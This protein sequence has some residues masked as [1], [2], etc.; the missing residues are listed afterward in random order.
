[1]NLLDVELS[2]GGGTFDG[3]TIEAQTAA[4]N[5]VITGP[6]A[7]TTGSYGIAAAQ[8]AT[9]Q[10]GEFNSDGDYTVGTTTTLSDTITS[11]ALVTGAKY[12]AATTGTTSGSLIILS[13][14]GAGNWSV[15]ETVAIDASP[16]AIVTTSTGVAVAHCNAG[17]TAG[18]VT[19][20]TGTGSNF[21][22]TE[23]YPTGKCANAIA[24]SNFGASADDLV[25]TDYADNQ[26]IF[27]QKQSGGTY[28]ALS[29]LKVG[30]GPSGLVAEDF[31]GDG[32][33]DVAVTNFTD[34]NV[35]ILMGGGGAFAAPVIVKLGNGPRE[36]V[37]GTFAT[38]VK[39]LAIVNTTDNSISILAGQ[40]VHE[41][42]ATATG[43]GIP[44][45]GTHQIAATYVGDAN[46][47]GSTSASLGLTAGAASGKITLNPATIA[48]GSATVGT[49]TTTTVTLKNTS[50]AAVSISSITITPKG[51]V[52]YTETNTCS[53]SV[54]AGATCTIQVTFD[55]QSAGA[56]DDF[57]AVT[58]SAG[59]QTVTLTGTGVAAAEAVR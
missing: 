51:T 6:F 27:L 46:Y 1:V 4:T 56:K 36:I 12:I 48:F 30:N 37:S 39:G 11:V 43:V 15:A 35:Y 24:V 28:K 21:T 22:K 44:G 49:K 25:V 57:V 16:V 8:G 31:D 20:L 59:T 40:A 34:D 17:E 14:D 54:A 58:D 18:D 13:T 33:T 3:G 38:G 45:T 50:S 9:I 26:L 53:A 52:S 10:F 7:G 5:A 41:S 19:I 32:N 55:P 2:K 42:S 47:A 29:P 23:T